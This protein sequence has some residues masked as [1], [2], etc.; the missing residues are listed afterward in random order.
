MSDDQDTNNTVNRRDFMATGVG[1]M[2][3]LALYGCST[4]ATAERVNQSNIERDPSSFTGKD[5]RNLAQDSKK[6][7]GHYPFV[8]IGSGYGGSVL[9]AR[10]SAKGKKVCILERG[11]E[12]HP[13][14]F[15]KKGTDL[16]TAGRTKVNPRGLVD[17][18][19]HKKSDVDVICASGLGGTSLLNAAIA[20]RPE[21]LV[22]QQKAWPKELREDFENGTITNYMDKAQAVLHST[23]HPDAMKMR[24]TQLHKK[25]SEELGLPFDELLLNV[26]HT[27][28]NN[29]K[30][31]YGIPQNACTLCGDCCSGCNVGSKNV[32][33]VNY[34]P[35][36]RNY[37]AEIYSLIEVKYVEKKNGKYIVHFVE[38][39]PRFPYLK[40]EGKIS[41]DS[42]IMAAGSMGST[43]IML[44]SE[45][46]GLRLSSAL[47]TKFS[48]NGDV[49]GL[50]YNGN[51]QT[52]ILG[53][54]GMLS[55]VT[56][57]G[58]AIMVYADYRKPYNDPK[59]VDI[60][61][62]YLLLDGTIP[63]ALSPLVAKA[64]ASYALA[65]PN[66][67]TQEQE[68]RARIDLFDTKE[69]DANG[70]LNSSMIFFACG[71]DTSGGRYILDDFE[72]RVHVKWK[73]VVDEKSFQFINR[74]M[75]KFAKVQG[76]VYIPNPRMSVFGK[77][78]MATHPLGGCPMGADAEAGV[79]DHLGRVFD[80]DGKIHKGFYVVDAS[81]IPH[82]LGATPLLTI[83]ALAERI[84][85]SIIADPT[86]GV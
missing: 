45:M 73:N 82:S 68:D 46:M 71:H 54:N 84:S 28:K 65:N 78:M 27:V 49:M 60:M 13:G 18:N 76:G 4:N 59:D 80:E 57:S 2:A 85:D 56:P 61:E 21:A 37:G 34:L 25:L 10:L 79:V 23:H 5:P 31:D 12:W 75:G 22:W 7:K 38:H 64:V 52:N 77:R 30:N 86:I 81:I 55:S 9:A 3:G 48:A 74:E 35:M 15:P 20:S 70:A 67:F 39:S 32:L 6:M 29:E 53:T 43:E 11:K 14:M 42:V 33:S 24:K 83:S 58:Q 47:G 17:M 26:N 50:A 51:T 72:D 8:I 40:E 1:A 69:V 66:K 19:L 44:K 16:T 63:T 62:R 36:A 41:A